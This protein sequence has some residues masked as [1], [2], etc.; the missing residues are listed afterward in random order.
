[1]KNNSKSLDTDDFSQKA[2]EATIKIGFVLL[3][4]SWCF[5]IIQ[6]FIN[7]LMWGMIIAVALH[8]LSWLGEQS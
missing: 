1:M 4:L 3:L 8:L 7:P 6:P 2:I 5:N